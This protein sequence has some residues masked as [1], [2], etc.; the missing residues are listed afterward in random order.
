MTDRTLI[1]F[2]ILGHLEM[3]GLQNN[4]YPQYWQCHKV[5]FSYMNSVVIFWKQLGSKFKCMI[6]REVNN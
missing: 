2:M 5:R 6:K 1:L 4:G 3:N